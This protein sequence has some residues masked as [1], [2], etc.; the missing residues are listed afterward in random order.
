[1]DRL[2]VFW[3]KGL[4]FQILFQKIIAFLY[5]LYREAVNNKILKMYGYLTV[6]CAI[7]CL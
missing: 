7:L 6:M 4:E 1:M 3:Q 5:V 2:S